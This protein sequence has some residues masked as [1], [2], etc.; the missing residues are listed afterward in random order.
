MNGSFERRGGIKFN[1]N[2]TQTRGY[3]V[4]FEVE[5][6]LNYPRGNAIVVSHVLFMTSRAQAVISPD[7]IP[8]TS[9]D[10]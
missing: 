9:T 1:G 8:N 5:K 6:N 3:S 2:G 10:L 4:I 7:N